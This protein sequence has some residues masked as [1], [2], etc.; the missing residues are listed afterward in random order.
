[1]CLGCWW[2]SRA[3][4]TTSMLYRPE[5]DNMLHLSPCH[6]QRAKLAL[7]RR[8]GQPLKQTTAGTGEGRTQVE[9]KRNALHIDTQG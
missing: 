1:M 2:V 3:Q 5:Q 4:T 9:R 8:D 6:G 7:L